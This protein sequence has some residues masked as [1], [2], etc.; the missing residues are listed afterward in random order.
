MNVFFDVD[1]TLISYEGI[2]RP[3]VREVFQALVDDGHRIYIWS[4]V[5]LRHR[6]LQAHNLTHFVS[7]VFV[8]PLED[9]WA[10]LPRLGVDVEPQFVIDDHSQV[11]D[12]FGGM[13][14][15]PYSYPSTHDTEMLRAY[16]MIKQA[17][18]AQPAEGDHRHDDETPPRRNA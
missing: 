1:Y 4:G 8:K 2:L 10:S 6:V 7:G 15:K 5:G 14:I 16:A 13:H 3:H 17:A 11:V 9:H 12:A 18:E